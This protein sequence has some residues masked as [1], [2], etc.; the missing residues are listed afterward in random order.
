MKNILVFAENVPVLLLLARLQRVNYQSTMGTFLKQRRH[1]EINAHHTSE[2][3][4]LKCIFMMPGAGKK[5]E[6]E[7]GF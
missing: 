3:V 5:M 1:S 2:G 4:E 7:E 6:M